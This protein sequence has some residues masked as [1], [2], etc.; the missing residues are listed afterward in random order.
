[1]AHYDYKMGL[2]NVGSYQ[3][4]GAPFVS[5]TIVAGPGPVLAQVVSF[6]NVTSWVMVINH[7]ARNCRVGFSQNGVD[8]K[9]PSPQGNYV[10]LAAAV[11]N[12]S[13]Q[14]GPLDLK[15]TEIWLSGSA[16]VDVIAGLTSIEATQINNFSVSPE[17]ARNWSGSVGAQVG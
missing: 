17:K 1:M 13:T 6:P 15:V 16:N 11:D 12:V 5:G 8:R 2:G 4:A 7:D 3:V 14:L 10:V 9:G